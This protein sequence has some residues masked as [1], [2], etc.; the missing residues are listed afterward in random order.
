M[1]DW[2]QDA[3]SHIKIIADMCKASH[4]S[5]WIVRGKAIEHLVGASTLP[6]SRAIQRIWLHCYHELNEGRVIDEEGFA[7]VPLTARLDVTGL[8]VICGKLPED[9]L[10]R[11][12]LDR[13]LHRMGLLMA[14]EPE[15]VRLPLSITIPLSELAK[16]DARLTASRPALLSM[17]DSAEGNVSLVAR[18]A[19]VSRQ[20][21]YDA[22]KRLQI[23]YGKARNRRQAPADE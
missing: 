18:W 9:D 7:F 8:L 14:G 22:L 23:P 4:A 2:I 12:Y 13:L 10:D 5:L 6:I 19:G 17:M 20:A 16:P 11:P 15:D 3:A 1:T 21:L